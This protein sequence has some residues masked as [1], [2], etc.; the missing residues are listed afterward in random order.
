MVRIFYPL[1]IL[2]SHYAVRLFKHRRS[3]ANRKYKNVNI[4][5]IYNLDPAYRPS[6]VR[7]LTHGYEKHT[8]KTQ[9]L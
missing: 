5:V 4:C 2:K 6:A 9:K 3:H 7:A 8:K 1:K